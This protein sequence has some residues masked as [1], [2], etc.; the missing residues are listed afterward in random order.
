MRNIAATDQDLIF[1]TASLRPWCSRISAIA[2][3]TFFHIGF[4]R[5]P[6]Q[7]AGTPEPPL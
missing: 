3:S 6:R 4:C 1:P 2:S 5:T 7:R